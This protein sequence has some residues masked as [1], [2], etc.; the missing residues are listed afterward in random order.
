MTVEI[1][2]DEVIAHVDRDMFVIGRH[3]IIDRE[4][5]YFAFQVDKPGVALDNIQLLQ[6]KK[7]KQWDD[8]R[9]GYIQRQQQRPPIKMEVRERYEMLKI[10]VHDKLYRTD[11]KYRSLVKSIDQQKQKQHDLYP[12]VFSTI[13]Q[14]LKPIATYRR[15]LQD[16][17]QAYKDLQQQINKAKRSIKDFILSTNPH[18]M[19]LEMSAYEAAFEKTRRIVAEDTKYVSLEQRQLELER[20]MQQL[21]PRLF[22]TNAQIQTTQQKARQALKTDPK[23]KALTKMT[24]DLTRAQLDYRHAANPE[25]KKL[26]QELFQ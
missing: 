11:E 10:N 26:W 9:D 17:D 23:F 3:P 2:G 6:A 20:Q 5:N 25:L 8:Q 22:I 7:H 13:K 24:G 15:Q 1:V 14:V 12:E 18:L 19:D 21:Y 4:R 16:N